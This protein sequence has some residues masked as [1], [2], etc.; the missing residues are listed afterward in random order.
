MRQIAAIIRPN[1]R[2]SVIPLF[3]LNSCVWSLRTASSSAHSSTFLGGWRF[4][5]LCQVITLS[6]LCA[7]HAPWAG[8]CRL[9]SWDTAI[10]LFDINGSLGELV[11]KGTVL[12]LS[13]DTASYIS[14]YSTSSIRIYLEAVLLGHHPFCSALKKCDAQCEMLIKKRTRRLGAKG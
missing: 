3:F 7:V 9:V 6:S 1:L 13:P 8:P 10:T 11:G 5:A 2:G 14:I 12:V 4:K